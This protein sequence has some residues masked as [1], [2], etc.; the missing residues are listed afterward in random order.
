VKVEVERWK[1]EV[2]HHSCKVFQ[3]EVVVVV[4]LKK[5]WALDIQNGEHGLLYPSV[6]E[7]VVA[8]IHL[9]LFLKMNT[10]SIV[11]CD[12]YLHRLQVVVVVLHHVEGVEPF[13]D[14][15]FLFFF[16]FFFFYLL[17][18]LLTK[19]SN[20]FFIPKV[21]LIIKKFQS[22]KRKLTVS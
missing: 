1:A 22:K 6:V 3:H 20:F 13:F 19:T 9:V 17:F 8:D 4:V 11:Y 12:P 18:K 2:I 14:K 15:F 5:H 16:F 7:V 10:I 21:C